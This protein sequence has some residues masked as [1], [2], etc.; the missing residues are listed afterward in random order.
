MAVTHIDAKRSGRS[1]ASRRDK[2]LSLRAS[3]IVI[4]VCSVLAWIMMISLGL[5][6]LRLGGFR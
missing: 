2:R 1:Q 4:G 5:A 3:V 6:G